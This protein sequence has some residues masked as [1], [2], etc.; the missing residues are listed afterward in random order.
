MLD[1]QPALT[2][3]TKLLEMMKWNKK[4]C[5]WKQ[6]IKQLIFF[7]FLKWL[8]IHYIVYVQNLHS[9]GNIKKMRNIRY[10]KPLCAGLS[11]ALVSLPDV[12]AS[13]AVAKN[14]NVQPCEPRQKILFV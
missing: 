3:V 10:L 2:A 13:A 1:V 8:K 5:G 6:K 14:K 4:Q 12:G 9:Q 7:F 11:G